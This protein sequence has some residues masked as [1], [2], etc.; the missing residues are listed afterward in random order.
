MIGFDD[1]P[2][3]FIL[4]ISKLLEGLIV[5]GGELANV[6]VAVLV[7]IQVVEELV[8]D[9]GA[10]IIIHTVLRKEQIHLVFVDLSIS[11]QV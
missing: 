8:D 9:L 7:R 6:D 3:E 5:L 10:M 4:L 2:L 11:I 1:L